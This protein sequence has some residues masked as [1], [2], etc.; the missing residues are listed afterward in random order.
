MFS[1]KSAKPALFHSAVRKT[2]FA[3]LPE[4]S[5]LSFG[6]FS[7]KTY[8]SLNA[9]SVPNLRKKYNIMYSYKKNALWDI[10][11]AQKVYIKN[12]QFWG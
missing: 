2:G 3:L 9:Q 1:G 4:F 5:D 7:K 11:E 6:N 8:K 12:M 10:L